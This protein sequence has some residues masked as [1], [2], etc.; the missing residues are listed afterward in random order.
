MEIDIS[1][2]TKI[3]HNDSGQWIRANAVLALENGSVDRSSS[4]SHACPKIS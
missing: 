1:S 4:Q 2:G 3:R